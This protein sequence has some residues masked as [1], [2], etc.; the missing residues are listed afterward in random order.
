MVDQSSDKRNVVGSNPT[1]EYTKKQETSP[2]ILQ[3]RLNSKHFG[4]LGQLEARKA[5]VVGIKVMQ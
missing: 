1:S 2:V 4:E 3:K 5:K